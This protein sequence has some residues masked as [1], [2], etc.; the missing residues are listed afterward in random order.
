[1]ARYKEYIRS[2]LA[3]HVFIWLLLIVPHGFSSIYIAKHNL[4]Y[5]FLNMAVLDGLLLLIIY[6]NLF[7]L[8]PKYF[9]QKK[10][11]VYFPVLFLLFAVFIIITFLTAKFI[12]ARLHTGEEPGYWD[13]LFAFFNISRYTVISF[14]LYGMKEKFDQEKKMD[15]VSLEKLHTEIN[16]LRA[17]VNPHFLFNT[18]NNVYGL[19]LEKSDKTPEVILKL[20]GMMDYMLYESGDPKVFLKNDIE[21]LENY[22]ELEKIRQGNHASLFFETRGD[23][24]DQ[25]IVPLLLLP[26]VEN[27]LKHGVNR[28]IEGAFLD[29]RLSV[30]GDELVFDVR[31]NYQAKDAKS[32]NGHGGIGL[33]NLKRRL[34]L[35][36]PDNY[37]LQVLDNNQLYQVHLKLKLV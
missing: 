35:L 5:Y 10:Y 12:D 19:A 29:V 8:V 34:E 14:L 22:L 37:R 31:N 33:I 7:L 9:K 26:L 21:N 13:V 4:P 36:Y 18:L 25:K 23:V 2:D 15:Q 6:L 28:L 3:Y 17:Q 32:Q 11:A 30:N 24:T 27:G 16:Y 1:M 20:S